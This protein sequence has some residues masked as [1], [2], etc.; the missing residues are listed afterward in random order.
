MQRKENQ[1]SRR[2]V[3]QSKEQEGDQEI[4]IRHHLTHSVYIIQYITAEKSDPSV[5]LPGCACS[6]G[7]YRL[8]GKVAPG[9][10]NPNCL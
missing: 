3:R 5:L 6:A 4:V 9:L 1:D 10:R 2:K 8:H 7:Y